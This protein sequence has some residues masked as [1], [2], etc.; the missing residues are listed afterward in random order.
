MIQILADK[1]HMDK[2]IVWKIITEDL[3][4]KKLCVQYI[5]HALTVVQREDRVTSYQDFFEILNN[6]PEFLNKIMMGDESW[7]FAY[8]PESKW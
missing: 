2:Q 5:P 1:F 3:G 4:K 8:N 7:C 6:D